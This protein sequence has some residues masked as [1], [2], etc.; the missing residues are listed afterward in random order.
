M[1]TQFPLATALVVVTSGVASA[2]RL[3]SPFGSRV[4]IDLQAGRRVTGELLAAERDTLWLLA[5]AGT[6]SSLALGDV[7]RAAVRQRGLT[8]TGVLVWSVVGAL[9]SGGALTAACASVDD[10]ECG[11][12]F[13]AVALSWALV[14]GIGAAMAGGG[15]RAIPVT[16][17]SLAPYARF[18]QGLPGGFEPAPHAGGR[19][20]P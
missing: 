12:V 10:A 6:L 9:V 14:G 4:T 8:A 7:Q 15:S 1:R 3:P 5:P 17:Q 19:P 13:P 2:Q 16:A 11:A 18:P 20:G